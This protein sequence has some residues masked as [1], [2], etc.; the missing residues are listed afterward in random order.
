MGKILIVEDDDDI[1]ELIAFNLEMS[2]Y[3][4]FKCGNGEEAIKQ[5]IQSSP[6]LILL[7]V[8]LPTIDGFEVCRQL[9]QKPEIQ[10]TPI[11]MLTARTD[12][13]DIIQGLETGAD[14]YITKPFRPKILMARVKAA[15]RRQSTEVMSENTTL[16]LH[17]ITIDHDRHEVILKGENI[18]LSRT[19]FSILEYLAQNPGFVYSRNQ[20]IDRVKGNGYAVTE[21]SVDVQILGIRKKL[22]DSGKYIETVRGI[23]YR[24]VSP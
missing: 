5:A 9:K 22:G 4:V 11:I 7:D 18:H 20:I 14:D 17:G 10:N 3:D 24:M 1:R 19:E 15:L 2:G 12:D 16:N 13:E 6:D 21:R 8:M 23:G